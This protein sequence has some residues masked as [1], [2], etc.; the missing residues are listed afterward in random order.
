MTV[1]RLIHEHG[2]RASSLSESALIL[3]S[4]GLR[5]VLCI[6]S[7]PTEDLELLQSKDATPLELQVSALSAAATANVAILFKTFALAYD[8]GAVLY[9]C[10]NLAKAYSAVVARFEQ[11][12]QIAGYPASESEFVQFGYQPEPYY[13]LDALL[14]ASRR[15]YDK[16]AHCVWEAF[17]GGGGMPNNI[18]DVLLRLR[19][20]PLPLAE[21]LRNSWTCF[22]ERLKDFRDCTQ[23]FASTDLGFGNI[24]MKRLDGEIWAAWARIPDNPEVKSKKKFTYTLGHDALTYG[25][26]VSNEVIS[27]ATEAVAASSVSATPATRSEGA[28]ANKI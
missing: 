3:R 27:L 17:E 26:E 18:A 22:G 16:I 19:S 23:H 14:S 21:R 20:C 13:E 6:E 11:I 15:V 25:W 12:R 10:R 1:T 9:H 28:T 5:P 7:R 24:T 8:A 4:Y 2:I